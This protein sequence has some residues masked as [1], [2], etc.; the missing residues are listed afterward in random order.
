MGLIEQSQGKLFMTNVY[1]WSRPLNVHCVD[2]TLKCLRIKKYTPWLH[3][4]FPVHTF[5]TTEESWINHCQANRPGYWYCAGDFPN[6]GDIVAG[7]S[8]VDEDIHYAYC[9]VTPDIKKSD[10][11]HKKQVIDGTYGLDFVCHNITNR[12]LYASP[13]RITLSDNILS[14]PL[15]GYKAVVACHLGVY[16][17]IGKEWQSTINRCRNTSSPNLRTRQEEIDAIHLRAADGNQESAQEIT[18][19]L[20][21]IDQD[22]LNDSNKKFEQFYKKEINSR[23]FN[24]DMETLLINTIFKTERAV[25]VNLA[26]KIYGDY[27]LENKPDEE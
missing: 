4:I 7:S 23:V 21:N 9:L 19:R 2:A 1:V 15:T 16:G 13:N 8:G 26:H 6:R 12:V 24:D 3:R 25:T 27:T 14:I 11:R 20:K 5:V 22:Y 17:R 18:E 10:P